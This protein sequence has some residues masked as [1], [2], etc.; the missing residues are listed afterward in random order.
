MGLEVG[1]EIVGIGTF[2]VLYFPIKYC[3]LDVLV[4]VETPYLK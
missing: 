3:V 4:C 1:R 2:G